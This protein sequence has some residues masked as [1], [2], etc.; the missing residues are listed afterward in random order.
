MVGNAYRSTIKI[1]QCFIVRHDKY[2]RLCIYL[3]ASDGDQIS[4]ANL[5][6]LLD[7]I[8]IHIE[9]LRVDYEKLNGNKASET[10]ENIRE[11]VQAARERQK[12]RFTKTDSRFPNHG[13]CT[14]IDRYRK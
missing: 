1:T 2:T 4:K 13:S 14:D 6:S 8:N 10:S 5:W 9:V 7:R 11:H 12:I 3:R